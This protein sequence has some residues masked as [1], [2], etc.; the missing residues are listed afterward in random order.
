MVYSYLVWC[1]CPQ[2]YLSLDQ[3][4]N[5]K[6]RSVA[7]KMNEMDPVRNLQLLQLHKDV[8]GLYVSYKM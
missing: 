4:Q 2:T 8:A 7:S 6:T 5:S 3:I 1:S